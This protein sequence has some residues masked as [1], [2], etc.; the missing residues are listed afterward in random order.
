MTQTPSN[1]AA[2]RQDKADKALSQATELYQQAIGLHQQGQLDQAEEVY[3]RALAYEPRHADALQMRGVIR[4]QKGDAAG[5][6]ELIKRALD[7]EPRAVEL[8]RLVEAVAENFSVVG[9]GHQLVIERPKDP[10]IV[11]ADV[12]AVRT[13]LG[14]LLEN[15]FKYSPDGGVITVTAVDRLDGMAEISVSDQGIGLAPG[16]PDNLFV[17]FY[18]GQTRARSRVRGGVGLGLSIVRRLAEA[19]GGTVGAQGEPG[20]G[21]RFWFTLPIDDPNTADE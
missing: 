3:R 4:L 7:I 18:Q 2:A 9:K 17:A 8:G 19:Q 11:R 13:G 10:V 1:S 14:Q 21:S 16:E 5:A 6:V 12:H 15:A 20:Q